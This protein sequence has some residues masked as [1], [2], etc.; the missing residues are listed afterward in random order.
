LI[1]GNLF[2]QNPSEALFQGEGN[3]AIYNNVFVNSQGHAIHIQPHNDLPRQVDIFHNT[4]LASGQGIRILRREGTPPTWPQRVMRNLVFA[5]QPI[6]G[7]V[8]IANL[9]GGFDAAARFLKHPY[10]DL[11]QL[12]VAPRMALPGDT[13]S[14]SL[15]LSAYPGSA[16]DID[17][18]ARDDRVIGAC[19]AQTGTPCPALAH[20]R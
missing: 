12:D 4:V 18:R 7:G 16:M 13:T 20:G 3:L 5:R 1:H 17:G 8:A 14:A 19:V 11:G 6:A 15:D 10:A 2:W 9:S